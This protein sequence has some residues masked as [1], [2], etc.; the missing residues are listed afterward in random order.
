[1][2]ENNNHSGREK[3]LQ[4]TTD[5]QDPTNGEDEEDDHLGVEEAIFFEQERN[6]STN[7]LIEVLE[8]IGRITRIPGHHQSS[9]I[10]KSLAVAHNVQ[11]SYSLIPPTFT[12]FFQVV[13][14]WKSTHD[15]GVGGANFL[16]AVEALYCRPNSLG[17][18]SDVWP[19]QVLAEYCIQ[20]WD[21]PFPN[22]FPPPLAT[23]EAAPLPHSSHHSASS[24]DQ[25][26]SVHICSIP[27]SVRPSWDTDSFDT[28]IGA[29]SGSHDYSV[30]IPTSV[31]DEEP[32][33]FLPIPHLSQ[34]NSVSFEEYLSEYVPSEPPSAGPSWLEEINHASFMVSDHHADDLISYPPMTT[35]VQMEEPL[36]SSETNDTIIEHLHVTLP[37]NPTMVTHQVL[38]WKGVDTALHKDY[39]ML[40]YHSLKKTNWGRPM[41]LTRSLY[42]GCFWV[43]LENPFEISE[44]LACKI[45]TNSLLTAIDIDETTLQDLIDKPLILESPK[46]HFTAVG[47]DVL[48]RTSL[49]SIVSSSLRFSG[50]SIMEQ[51]AK[52]DHFLGLLCSANV[53]RE[54]LFACLFQ[55]IIGLAKDNHIRR[56]ADLFPEEVRDQ[57][58][59]RQGV[60]GTLLTIIYHTFLCW[61]STNSQG[62]KLSRAYD[63]IMF[64]LTDMYDNPELYPEFQEVVKALPFI[65]SKVIPSSKARTPDHARLDIGFRSRRSS[66][67]DGPMSKVCRQPNYANLN[68]GF[69]SRCSSVPDGPMSKVCRRPDHIKLNIGFRSRRSSVPD[70]PMSK[71][72]WQ[73]DHANL[74]IGFRSRRSSVPDGPMS[75]VCRQPN[76]ANL[77]IGFRSRRSS[78]P[79]GPMSN[80]SIYRYGSELQPLS[81][82]LSI[83]LNMSCINH[84]ACM[85]SLPVKGRKAL[86]QVDIWFDSRLTQSGVALRHLTRIRTQLLHAVNKAK[87]TLRTPTRFDQQMLLKHS[88][89]IWPTQLRRYTEMPQ[90]VPVVRD[91]N[92]QMM[93]VDP[94]SIDRREVHG[95]WEECIHPSGATYHYNGKMET[96]QIF[97][98]QG[99]NESPG[100]K[101]I[102]ASIE[103]VS[104]RIEELAGPDGAMR[105]PSIAICVNKGHHQYLNHYGQPEAR[106]MR[107]HSLGERRRDLEHS[108]LMTGIA[109][110]M[111][112]IPIMVLKC[113]RSIYIDGLVN[114]VDI[115][116]FT[117][118]FSVQAKAQ[119]TVASVIL[120]VNASIL[121]IPGIGTQIA[122]KTLCSISFIFSVYCILGCTTCKGRWQPMNV[123]LG[124][125]IT[126]D[127]DTARTCLDPDIWSVVVRTVLGCPDTPPLQLMRDS[128][129][130]LQT[131]LRVLSFLLKDRVYPGDLWEIIGECTIEV[132][133]EA[134]LL[135]HQS[136]CIGGSKGKMHVMIE[137]LLMEERKKRGQMEVSLYSQAIEHLQQHWLCMH[138]MMTFSTT[139]RRVG[140]CASPFCST[141]M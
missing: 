111:F 119:T 117:D 5:W 97:S 39:R 76:Y 110:T 59:L 92:V 132:K 81:E 96:R 57:R 116:G 94:S 130:K 15:V 32:T 103:L 38:V 80:A 9:A 131:E 84:T 70:G 98:K 82:K 14:P 27:A 33:T 62:Q 67:P 24:I 34:L 45:I 56:V 75:K 54:L 19:L 109:V 22:G 89:P 106:L 133:Q 90:L 28:H 118:D 30:V 87:A 51:N 47:W 40:I 85:G 99:F 66:V 26:F 11:Y 112:W 3:S 53:D 44:R 12:A 93:Q 46:G 102:M 29:A 37:I 72:C 20:F 138:D 6:G 42:L 91:Y 88:V 10:A 121:A 105:E 58:G 31:R 79:D 71:V 69:R 41:L 23:I 25:D 114:G 126:R 134:M 125:V 73:P 83:F 35:S 68:I 115:K 74:N 129:V 55:P 135:Q 61:R 21:A 95:D 124:F 101:R 86:T 1:M 2:Q 107:T 137:H 49:L 100:S 128:G 52:A 113:L 17:R 36:I 18:A 123:E 136:T 139:L 108:P 48:C 141:A 4:E 13:T 64:A 60:V 104:H 140:P 16:R 78:V 122:T 77:N 8:G 43:G 120:A 50:E 7:S 127:S 63:I 65:R